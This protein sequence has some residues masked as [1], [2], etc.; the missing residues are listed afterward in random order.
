MKTDLGLGRIHLM[1]RVLYFIKKI[2]NEKQKKKNHT[3][4]NIIISIRINYTI[5]YR[6]P[7]PQLIWKKAAL[8]ILYFI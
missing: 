7:K 5:Q 6:K 2:S 8:Y 4:Q 1:P 3:T